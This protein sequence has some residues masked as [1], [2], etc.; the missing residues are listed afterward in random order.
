MTIYQKKNAANQ[1]SFFL[2][3]KIAPVDDKSFPRYR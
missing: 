1:H 3:I 2:Y